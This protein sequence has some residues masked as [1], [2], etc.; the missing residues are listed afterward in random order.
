MQR[1]LP[2]VVETEPKPDERLCNKQIASLWGVS[3]RTVMRRAKL[4]KFVP[5]FPVHAH[6]EWLRSDFERLE[7]RWRAHTRRSRREHMKR[8]TEAY[9]KNRPLSPRPS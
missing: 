8:K 5:S 4:L 7:R 1:P 2:A 6:Y 9:A 3:V